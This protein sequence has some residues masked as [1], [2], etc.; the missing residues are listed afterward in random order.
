MGFTEIEDEFITNN[1]G[2]GHFAHVLEQVYTN[3][4]FPN[5]R[6]NFETPKMEV[7]LKASGKIGFE[8]WFFK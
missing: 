3:P 5:N 4:D 6:Y 7:S 8:R 1:N 2:L